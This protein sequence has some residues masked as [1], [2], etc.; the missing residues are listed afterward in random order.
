MK[1]NIF[2]VLAFVLAAKASFAENEGLFDGHLSLVEIVR[3]TP[4]AAS[5]DD[6]YVVPEKPRVH[7]LIGR[8]IEVYDGSTSLR[9]VEFPMT[10]PPHLL[11]E[12]GQLTHEYTSFGGVA[13]ADKLDVGARA[14]LILHHRRD[15]DPKRRN[16]N[17]YRFPER[18]VFFALREAP[19]FA[20]DRVF[21]EYFKAQVEWAEWIA[22]LNKLDEARARVETL[23][24]G[25][26]E[27]SPLISVSAVHLFNRLYP[28]LAQESFDE[29]ALAPG[30]PF[31]ARMA[32]DH[33][34]CL[35]K[36]S[37]WVDGM[38]TE[39]ETILNNEASLVPFG[40]D[41]LNFRVNMIDNGSW[42]GGSDW[43][44]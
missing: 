33:E 17:P 42:F 32:I 11:G 28:D 19:K 9:G 6:G 21:P 25:I 43:K 39:L 16:F 10:P 27:G 41:L 44:E 2:V 31:F 36:G 18:S 5:A 30:T 20:F 35:S 23:T 15:V 4:Y 7:N 38:Q 34:L 8:V 24:R 13:D 22:D 1:K 37:T 3:S 26:M 40:S 14:I 12:P 29:F